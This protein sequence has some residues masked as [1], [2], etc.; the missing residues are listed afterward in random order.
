MC[1]DAASRDND[2]EERRR[3]APVSAASG[4]APASEP[5][6]G[7]EPAGT[8]PDPRLRTAFLARVGLRVQGTTEPSELNDAWMDNVELVSAFSGAILPR[9]QWTASFAVSRGGASSG[10]LTPGGPLTL[11]D[12]IARF[13]LDP[14]LNLW[15][16]R[17]LVAADRSMLSG[18]YFIGAWNYPGVYSVSGP[19]VVVAPK[20]ELMGRATGAAVWGHLGGGH[21]KYQLGAYQLEA[22]QRS[23]LWSGRLSAAL[24]DPEPEFTNASSYYGQKD[25]LSIG[26]GAQWQKDGSSQLSLDPMTLAPVPGAARDYS[27]WNADLLA[28]FGVAGGTLTAEAAVYHFDGYASAAP[29]EWA[30]FVLGAY[31]L[32]FHL[33][34]GRLQPLVRLQATREPNMRMLDC[35]LNYVLMG[36]RLRIHLGY[37]RTDMGAGPGGVERVGNALQFGA[38]LLQL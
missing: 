35:F 21:F 25:I 8:P 30:G 33:P 14:A 7:T 34:G 16:G 13:E 11:L 32:P 18:P 5:A 29:V 22:P 3:G 23:P 2:P 12:L 26:L 4:A 20:A 6:A 9:V 10:P 37:Q 27:E 31:L 24:L 15:A 19:P 28:E 38:Q 36:P 1:F 17:L